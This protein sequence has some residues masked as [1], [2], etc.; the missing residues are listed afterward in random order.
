MNKKAGMSILVK[1]LMWI[2]FA[3]ILLGIVYI[4]YQFI[5]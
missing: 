3:A 2:F 5:S 4:L 1:T